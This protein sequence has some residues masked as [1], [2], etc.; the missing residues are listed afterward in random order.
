M[1]KTE[2]KIYYK[3]ISNEVDLFFKK[4]YKSEILFCSSHHVEHNDENII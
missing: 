1:V 2:F 4:I 3:Y